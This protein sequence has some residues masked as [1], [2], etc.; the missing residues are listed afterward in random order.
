VYSEWARLTTEGIAPSK[1]RKHPA[2]PSAIDAASIAKSTVGQ[3]AFGIERWNDFRLLP[4][5]F[6]QLT[7]SFAA[8]GV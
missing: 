5:V 7:P 3:P 2:V 6:P 8:V 1:G 4:T